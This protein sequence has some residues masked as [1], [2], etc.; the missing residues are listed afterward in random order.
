[1]KVE[2]AHDFLTKLYP[3]KT[4]QFRGMQNKAYFFDS[5]TEKDDSENEDD[6]EQIYLVCKKGQWEVVINHENKYSSPYKQPYNLAY[7]LDNFNDNQ[8]GVKNSVGFDQ[9]NYRY[10]GSTSQNYVEKLGNAENHFVQVIKDGLDI[11]LPKG[12][13]ST[14]E[15][16]KHIDFDKITIQ[17]HLKYENLLLDYYSYIDH[18]LCVLFSYEDENQLYNSLCASNSDDSIPDMLFVLEKIKDVNLQQKYS[19]KLNPT[20]ITDIKHNIRALKLEI[21]QF[22]FT[23]EQK[24][25][26]HSVLKTLHEEMKNV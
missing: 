12:Q 22:R 3:E 1:M 15:L 26:M 7:D 11:S 23:S 18:R 5:V 8:V 20:L 2:Q 6:Y 14:Y 16:S 19:V 25:K 10:Y 24:K 9:Y 17:S 4:W 13:R 21:K